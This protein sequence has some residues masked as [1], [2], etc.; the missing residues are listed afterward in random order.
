[1][2]YNYELLN[3]S[4]FTLIPGFTA[5][6]AIFD[7]YMSNVLSGIF[8]VVSLL[9]LITVTS[10]YGVLYFIN[11]ELTDN[12]YMG[13]TVSLTILLLVVFCADLRSVLGVKN[14]K[15]IEGPLSLAT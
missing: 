9:L 5:V 1:M 13:V 7:E 12:I 2:N 11:P 14:H 4:A 6:Q 3:V 15:S 8:G 10:I